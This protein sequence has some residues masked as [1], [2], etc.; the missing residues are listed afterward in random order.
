M[1][2]R[3]HAIV[4][5]ISRYGSL[6]PELEGPE[7]DANAIANWLISPDGGAL[8]PG[9]VRTILSSK[10]AAVN[11]A[12][13][14]DHRYEYE[15]T[16]IRATSEFGRLMGLTVRN[17]GVAPRVGR[18]LYIY[19]S[20]HGLT[21][22][23]DPVTSTQQSALAMAN[24]VEGEF[25]EYLPGLMYA[26]WFRASHS[27]DE[28]LLFMDCCRDDRPEVR[29]TM[30]INTK[31]VEGGRPNTVRTFYAWATQWDS[32][33]FEMPLGDPAET[34]GVFTFALLEA[35][36]EATPDAL[37]RLTPQS[38]VG[39]LRGRVLQLRN[40]DSSQFPQ[41]LPE[42]PDDK[43]VLLTR[44]SAPRDVNLVVTFDAAL[45]GR[46]A[47]VQKGNFEPVLSSE[48]GTE[49]WPLSLPP[50]IY[51]IHVAGVDK[52]ASFS[53]RPGQTQS[54]HVNG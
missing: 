36:R 13:S 25:Y 40:G 5:G 12:L 18:R 2:D 49:P 4:V 11:A 24:C 22:E 3:D 54:V 29:M 46:R 27:F 23:I 52:D 7:R 42:F 19:L 9:N 33:A 48:V 51:I 10:Y 38:I 41:F 43:I 1:N 28:I 16:L 32:R 6:R 20:G 14:D 45:A 26:E 53:L 47:E 50:G 44:T 31:I 15:P 35:L 39:H 34:R 37:G 21:P 8:P 17:S 30:S